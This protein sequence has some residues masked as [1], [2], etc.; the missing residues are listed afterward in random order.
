VCCGCACEWSRANTNISF[1]IFLINKYSIYLCLDSFLPVS[2]SFLDEQAIFCAIIFLS[3]YGEKAQQMIYFGEPIS[4]CQLADF[5]LEYF[6][7]R[8]PSND[9]S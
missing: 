9:E 4:N 6:D 2:P 1:G 8:C 3:D 5:K 7:G